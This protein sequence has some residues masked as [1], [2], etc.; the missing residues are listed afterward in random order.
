MQGL[1][2]WT[3]RQ[4]NNELYRLIHGPVELVGEYAEEWIKAIRAEIRT[5]ELENGNV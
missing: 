2:E 4:L 5:R 3:I 1:Q